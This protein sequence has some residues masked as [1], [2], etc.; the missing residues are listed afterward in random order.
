MKTKTLHYYADPAHG[1]IKV[2]LKL[3]KELDIAKEISAFSYSRGDYAYLEE[4]R[5]ASLLHEALKS[6]G[7]TPK[8]K[9]FHINKSS[10]IRNYNSYCARNLFPY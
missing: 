8:Y 9:E 5:D 1:W 6:K 10:K 7:I 2:P 3:L 4:D